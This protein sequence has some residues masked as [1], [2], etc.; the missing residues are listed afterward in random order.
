[1]V[2]CGKHNLSSLGS[3]SVHGM[4]SRETC[5]YLS[6]L[7]LLNVVNKVNLIEIYQIL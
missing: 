5:I 4:L 6:L 3:G 1:M 2:V 7:I